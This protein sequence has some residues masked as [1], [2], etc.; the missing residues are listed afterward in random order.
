VTIKLPAGFKDWR[1]TIIGFLHAANGMVMAIE[2]WKATNAELVY[3]EPRL[4]ARFLVIASVLRLINGMITPS[5]AKVKEKTEEMVDVKVEA[6]VQKLLSERN[7]PYG[8][9]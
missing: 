6:A 5:T 7:P 8:N 2:A 9:R 4:W 1:T 3:I